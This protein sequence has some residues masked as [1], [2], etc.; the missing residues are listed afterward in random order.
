MLYSQKY[1][2]VAYYFEELDYVVMLNYQISF[3]LISII[4]EYEANVMILF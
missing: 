4:I 1:I 3:D 2:V